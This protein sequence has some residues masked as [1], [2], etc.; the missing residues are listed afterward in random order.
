MRKTNNI[1][2][3][4]ELIDLAFLPTTPNKC[5]AA[6]ADVVAAAKWFKANRNTLVAL[7][8]DARQEIHLAHS[9][10]GAVYDPTILTRIDALLAGAE[11]VE[12]A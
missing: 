2:R 3:L 10:D 8:V 6:R 7:L 4:L 5:R 1:G 12:G 11:G 9:K